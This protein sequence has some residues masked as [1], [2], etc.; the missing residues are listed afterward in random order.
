MSRR[1][2][3]LLRAGAPYPLARGYGAEVAG[4]INLASNESPYGPSPRVLKVLKREVARI[5]SYPDPKAMEL[6]RAIG[7]YLRAK[8]GCVAIGNGSDE[9][10]DL[11]CKAFLNPNERA[12]IPLPTFAMYE[13][14]CKVNGGAPKFYPLPNFEWRAEELGQALTRAKLAFVGRPNNPT[15]NGM[16][17]PSLRKLLD[18]GKLIIIDEAYAEF[19]GYSVARL[20]PKLENLL[21]L[22]TFS[23]AFGLAGLRIGYA[24]GNPE[25]VAV[26]ERIRAPFNVNSLAQ[27][28]AIEALLDKS[29]LRRVVAKVREGRA[30]LGRELS[31]LGMRVLPSDANFLMA[32]VSPLGTDASNFCDFLAKRG[33][34]IRDLSNLQGA[35]PNW[36]RV[37]VGTEQ[38]NEKLMRVLEKFKGGKK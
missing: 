17:L 7:D 21:V 24:I 36:V 27:A 33:I 37:T 16:S 30:Y 10:V 5:G 23:K 11:A 4:A 3:E 12:L 2:G 6:K 31:K 18:S 19:A 15:G 25:S 8:A 14:A 13:L 26:L 34:L 28:A 22:R 20:A 38:Q 1:V 35:G 29:Y 32:D 9:L